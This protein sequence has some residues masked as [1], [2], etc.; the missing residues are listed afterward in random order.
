MKEPWKYHDFE[1]WA[2]FLKSKHRLDKFTEFQVSTV[3]RQNRE[4]RKE[5]EEYYEEEE[6]V[7]R[8]SGQE[9][10]FCSVG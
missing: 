6:Q 10:E 1:Q 2:L 4:E 5:E 7:E 8:N 3:M 9:E